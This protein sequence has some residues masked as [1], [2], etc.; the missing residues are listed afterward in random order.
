MRNLFEMLMLVAL[1]TTSAAQNP[2]VFSYQAVVRNQHNELVVNEE[3]SVQV[4]LY[5]DAPFGSAI[6]MEQHQVTSNSNGLISMLIGEGNSPA[7]DILAV[8]WSHAYMTTTL[9]LAG[10][11]T[12]TDTC[13]VTAAPYAYYADHISLAAIEEQL[14][15]VDIVTAAALTDSLARYEPRAHLRDTL[16][17]FLQRGELSD[18]LDAALQNIITPATLHDSL[19]PY[20][21]RE[22]FNNSTFTQQQMQDALAPYVTQTDLTV[23]LTDLQNTL[24]DLLSIRS[25]VD[26]FT[27]PAS[28]SSNFDLSFTP[29]NGRT[30]LM[31]IN[32]VCVST[33]CFSITNKTLTYRPANNGNKPLVSGDRIQLYY[34][35]QN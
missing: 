5:N 31:Y 35:Y 3:I 10:G 2:P 22:E 27:V 4:A 29:M 21:T 26:E 23:A 32:G 28:P 7:G 17:L 8:V 12:A 1:W 34:F 16:A 25:F 24:A 11:Y 15:D 20:L 6:Y 33:S 18:S 14:G 30:V 19:Q 9:T 13:R